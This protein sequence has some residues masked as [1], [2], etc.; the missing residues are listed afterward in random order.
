MKLFVDRLEMHCRHLQPC[1]GF[2][3]NLVHSG[4]NNLCQ[5]TKHAAIASACTFAA[6]SSA[7]TVATALHR[8]AC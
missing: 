8:P 2:V 7:A 4:L 1:E 6:A 3:Q 5:Q